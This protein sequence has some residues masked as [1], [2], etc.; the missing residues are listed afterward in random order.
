[1]IEG[2]PTESEHFLIINHPTQQDLERLIDKFSMDK[3]QH[4][5]KA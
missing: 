5:Q 2:F 4:T 3:T 1:M